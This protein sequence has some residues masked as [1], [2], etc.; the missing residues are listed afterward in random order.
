MSNEICTT[1]L[2][3]DEWKTKAVGDLSTK[4]S[5]PFCGNNLPPGYILVKEEKPLQEHAKC[6]KCGYEWSGFVKLPKRCPKC[7]SYHWME[8]LIKH[9]CLK[10]GYS[11]T[12]RKAEMPCR[13]PKCR[14]NKWNEIAKPVRKEDPLRVKKRTKEES[15]SLMKTACKRCSNGE[16]AY[17]V[18]VDMC[19]PLLD[20]LM[21]MKEKGK[22][23]RI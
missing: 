23:I 13:C 5:C 16:S 8:P 1:A 2:A 7:G 6:N 12:P 19:V 11:W 14:S 15:I 3:E 4:C 17:E 20:I 9:K 18:S 10:C 21:T 22:T